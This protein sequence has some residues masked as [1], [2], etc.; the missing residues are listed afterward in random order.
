MN[1]LILIGNGFDLA[2]GLP[3]S[4]KDFIDDFW[5]NIH[6]NYKKDSYKSFVYINDNYFRILNYHKEVNNFKDFEENLI[7]YQNEYNQE[8]DGY[9]DYELKTRDSKCKIFHFTNDF[10]KKINSKNSIENWVDIENEYFS[11][12]KKISKLTFDGFDEVKT[13][14]TRKEKVILL[15]QEFEQIKN[16]FEKYLFEKVVQKF[17]YNNTEKPSDWV[18]MSELLKP[19]IITRAPF[20]KE[21]IEKLSKEFS[22][23]E[24]DIEILKYRELVLSN[25]EIKPII[26]ESQILSFNYTPT[27]FSYYYF[28]N[29]NFGD[30]ICSRNYIHG[31]IYSKQNEINFGFGDEMDDFYKEIENIGDNE[32]LKNFKSFQYSNTTNYDDLL[33]YIDSEK[34]QVSI[35]GHSCGLSDRLLLNTIF[36]HENCRSIKI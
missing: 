29:R 14:S 10:F 26:F 24:D 16:L 22:F 4:Y 13:K 9:R 36:E 28:I 35:L 27:V 5:I 2:H 11:E 20:I 32:Y 23:Q 34:F 25:A 1:K 12:L 19:I 3:T 6:L 7:K 21:K 31:E 15:N 8:V 30:D 18:G 17:D 33:R